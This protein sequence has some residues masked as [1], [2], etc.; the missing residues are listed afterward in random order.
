[1]SSKL[2]QTHRIGGK[3]VKP[4]YN[5]EDLSIELNF[6]ND[7]VTQAV[8]VTE[9][10]WREKEHAQLYKYFVDG[11][12][13]GVGV[14]E[15][16]DHNIEITNG[17]TT[18]NFDL[19][20]DL[21]TALFNLADSLTTAES[22]PKQEI[23]WINKVADSKSFEYMHSQGEITSS[24]YV[25]IP[26]IIS[27]VPDYK[28][29][30]IVTLTIVVIKIE[31]NDAVL[32][33]TGSSLEGLSVIDTIG[34][35]I[36]LIF[37][38]IYVAI[39]FLTIIDLLIDLIAL[40]IQRVKYIA[41]MK[42][43]RLLEIGCQSFGLGYASPILQSEPFNRLVFIP[44]SYDQPTSLIDNRIVGFFSS[45]NNDQTGYYRGTLGD[46]LRDI[47]S[48]FNFR[49][50][51]VD[52]ILNLLPDVFVPDSA[53]FKLKAYD[54][55]TVSSNAGDFI[56]QFNLSWS[57]DMTD[58]NTI[59]NW[60]GTNVD[61]SIKPTVVNDK[62]N[63]FNG[64]GFINQ[65]PFARASRKTEL[66]TPE[67]VAAILLNVLAPV[68]NAG[69]VAVNASISVINKVKEFIED[70]KKLP[71][72]GKKIKI[73]LEPTPKVKPINTNLIENRIGMMLLENDIINVKK[74]VLMDLSSDPNLNKVS[75][76]NSTIINAK[77]FYNRFFKSKNTQFL[78]RS[79][80]N[81]EMNLNDVMN[82]K[83]EGAL[84]MPD[85]SIA[86]V[87]SC[88]WQIVT[89]TS[90]ILLDIP[91]IYNNNKTE[92]INEPKGR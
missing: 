18:A 54:E 77:Y 89:Q 73:E 57:T 55:E 31:I 79:I 76:D 4:P 15:G 39:L 52:G 53:T 48:T 29:A 56:S 9:F 8:T 91:Y 85:G 92:V 40:I 42:L 74:L 6:D 24:D 41:G 27:S 22:A 17:V 25:F 72:I 84:S 60:T 12:T 58:K 35:V 16:L 75:I 33:I 34:G 64:V 86:K 14:M 20:I 67:R 62:A 61:V 5:Y 3:I 36:S 13:G 23:D 47:K 63:V 43:N 65:F 83:K 68:I 38:I 30:F 11:A 28:E 50:N 87:I 7:G 71:F 44:E 21:R 59:K 81:V 90:E 37:N 46:L 88:K 69:I 32:R 26:Y 78:G 82:V 51:I 49:I 66:T 45:K 1:M 80:S 70:L 19:T 10:E 2:T